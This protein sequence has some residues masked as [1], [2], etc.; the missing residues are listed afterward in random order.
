MKS[1]SL[2]AFITTVNQLGRTPKGF[3]RSQETPQAT[4]K[5][6]F[7]ACKRTVHEIWE[8]YTQR[9]EELSRKL[10]NSKESVVAYLFGFHLPNIARASELYYRSNSRH[11]WKAKL[12]GK[13]VRVYDIG[14]GTAAMSL[15]LG[16]TGDYFLIDSCGP[17]LDAAKI[18]AEA[19]GLNA[20]TSRKNIEELEPKHFTSKEGENMVHI[21][22]LGYV[23]NELVKNAPARRKLLTLMTNHIKRKESCLIFV[24]EPALEFMS[25]PAMELRDTLCENGYTALYPCP[26]SS[27][28][29]MLER[30]KD[31]C[32]TEGVWKQPPLAE[33][34]DDQLDVNRSKHASTLFAFASPAMGLT[35]DNKP[36]VVGRP[37]REAG[38]DRYKGFFD[39][40]LCDENGITKRKP[41]KPKQAVLRGSIFTEE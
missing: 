37:V 3:Q 4:F 41:Q 18:L 8:I 6:I 16:V 31:W 14:C 21:Y 25:R 36:I 23:W 32:Y 7:K 26:H 38:I 30:P 9:R 22:L 24:A 5:A 12:K 34:L 29:P 11:D 2:K 40:L 17:L 33:W 27:P 28:C 13:K 10:M 1:D 39:Y 19:A 15:A 35:S 20:K